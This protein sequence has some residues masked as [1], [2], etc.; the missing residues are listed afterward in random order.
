MGIASKIVPLLIFCSI[1]LSGCSMQLSSTTNTGNKE[2]AGQQFL[3]DV[4]TA[5]TNS[6]L[7]SL[8]YKYPVSDSFREEQ[9]AKM[10]TETIDNKLETM[11]FI[12]NYVKSS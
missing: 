7:N 12:D 9:I 2:S 3:T 10:I 11:E 6:Y 5:A 4:L 1:C 8:E